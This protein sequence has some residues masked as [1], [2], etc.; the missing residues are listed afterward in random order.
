VSQISVPETIREA[1]SRLSSSNPTRDDH[2]T[3]ISW[4]FEKAADIRSKN[5]II[6]GL[7]MALDRTVVDAINPNTV[8]CNIGVGLGLGDAS[9]GMSHGYGSEVLCVSVPLLIT[10]IPM[11]DLNRYLFLRILV[12]R[13]QDPQGPQDR[14]LPRFSG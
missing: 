14:L 3:R 12:R 9:F 11:P 7:V 6:I 8:S 10:N 5:S 13:S 2:S 4:N 1:H